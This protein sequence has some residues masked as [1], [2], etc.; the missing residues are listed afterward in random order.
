[1]LAVFPLIATA[2][3][4]VFAV[5]LGRQ[6]GAR[7]RPHALAWGISLALFSGASAALTLGMVIGWSV[8]LFAVYWLAGALL[9]VP[10]LAVGQ[11][12]LM[13]PRRSV[14]WWT[15]GGLATVWALVFMAMASIDVAALR[16]TA[17]I[18]TGEVLGDSSVRAL[19]RP[20]SGL[21]TLV[22]VLGSAWSALR[23]RRWAL[24]L[25]PLGVLVVAAGSIGAREGSAMLHSVFLAVG[26]TVMYGGF[27]AT[28][29][30]PKAEPEAR[31]AEA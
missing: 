26:V 11:L 18:P 9:S 10:M 23:T 8:P 24:L 17:Q 28:T 5:Q 4:A 16:A 15:I 6:Y 20:F 13:D 25:I 7:R 1:M 27:R 31:A 12:H 22:V 29:R 14:L 19:A 21:G 30:V 3:A 2:V